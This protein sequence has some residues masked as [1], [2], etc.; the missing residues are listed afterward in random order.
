MVEAL[1]LL[2]QDHSHMAA[3]LR[4]LDRQ[5]G[6]FRG[7]RRPDYDV[8]AGILDYFLSFPDASH[9]PRED[10]IFAKLR[11]RR[12]QAIEAI[13]DLQSEHRQLAADAREF[14]T[15]LR[16]VLEEAEIPR[17]ALYGRARRF[18]D[19]QRRHIATEESVFFPA[20]EA[21]LTPADWT[22]LGALA[23]KAD[24]GE[25]FEQ[26]RQRILRWQADDEADEA[27]KSG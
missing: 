18:I 16:A 9:H 24:L 12:P 7:G 5:I 13:G 11:D 15:A 8:I 21:S 20:A 25:R 2:R 1:D 17:E 27:P 23:A 14:L 3:L 10:L 19:R 22:E 26:L 6:D 4:M